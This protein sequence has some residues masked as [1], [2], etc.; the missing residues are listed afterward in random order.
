MCW[1]A[2]ETAETTGSLRASICMEGITCLQY[3]VQVSYTF[4]F[5]YK[6][7]NLPPSG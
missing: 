4:T 3:I 2:S 1:I 6:R 7:A 5:L